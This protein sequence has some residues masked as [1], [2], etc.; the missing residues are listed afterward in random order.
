MKRRREDEML[1]GILLLYIGM[2]LN[3]PTLYLIGCWVAILVRALQFYC[4]FVAGY[5]N[6]KSR[7]QKGV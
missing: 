2:R 6:G 3:F 1:V 5:K 4:G 7:T